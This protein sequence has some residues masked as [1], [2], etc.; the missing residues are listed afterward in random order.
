MHCIL[1]LTWNLYKKVQTELASYLPHS[2]PSPAHATAGEQ[3]L[4]FCFKKV[5][6]RRI[7]HNQHIGLPEDI[8]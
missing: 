4:F 7:D 8:H 5:L 1:K 3:P 6:Q 2:L